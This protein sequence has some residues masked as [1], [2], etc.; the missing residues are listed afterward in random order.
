VTAHLVDGASG[1]YLWSETLDFREP[2]FAA[3]ET[4]AQA[5]VMK[6]KSGGGT[7]R[8][9]R[10]TDNLAARNLYLQGRYHMNQRTE[11]GLRSKAVEF[12]ERRSSKTVSTR[13]HTA[14][15]RMAMVS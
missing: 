10:P 11:E 6:L 8:G 2:D 7:V 15:L 14:V 4:V 1:S 3:Q 12:F 5:I 13:W 9:R